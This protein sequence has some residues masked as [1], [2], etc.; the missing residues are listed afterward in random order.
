MSSRRTLGIVLIGA[1][2]VMA[3]MTAGCASVME[4]KTVSRIAP[5]WF[6]AKSKEVKGQGYP[7]LSDVPPTV[8]TPNNRATLEAE[9]KTLKEVR[10]QLA[11]SP[12]YALPTDASDDD[13]RARAAQL[14]A[15]TE[16]GG[17]APQPRPSATPTP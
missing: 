5:D 2:L 17:A 10:D 8:P 7:K 15:Q 11:G 1:P 3:A 9:A 6:E 14:R 16:E 12:D 13:I 4:N